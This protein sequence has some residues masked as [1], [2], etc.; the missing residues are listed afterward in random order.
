VLLSIFSVANAALYFWRQGQPLEAIG[1]V[2]AAPLTMVLWPIM[3][4]AWWVFLVLF[5]AAIAAAPLEK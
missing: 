3:T 2:I 5:V 4:G 1:V